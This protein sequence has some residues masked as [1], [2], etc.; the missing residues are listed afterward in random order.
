MGRSWDSV[1]GRTGGTGTT[2][3]TPFS[4]IVLIDSACLHLVVLASPPL[5][6]VATTSSPDASHPRR[7]ASS[8]EKPTA[9]SCPHPPLI[10]VAS[11]SHPLPCVATDPSRR[12]RSGRER[13]VVENPSR[14]SIDRVL[15]SFPYPRPQRRFIRRASPRP[16]STCH[17]N[18]EQSTLSRVGWGGP[19]GK[20]PG[21]KHARGGEWD[22]GVR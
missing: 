21:V 20:R 4:Y 18:F 13:A 8:R 15:V 17:L 1:R 14:P 7:K 5:A 19:P 2:G 12:T 3:C 9:T 10:S 11:N 22:M 16:I 6:L